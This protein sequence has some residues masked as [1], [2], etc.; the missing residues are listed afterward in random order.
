M[1]NKRKCRLLAEAALSELSVEERET[2]SFPFPLFSLT[3][4]M[5]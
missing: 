4:L 5:K 2:F 1:V 3:A